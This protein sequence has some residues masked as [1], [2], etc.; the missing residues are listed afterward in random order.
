M[1]ASPHF[2]VQQELLDPPEEGH[3][4]REIHEIQA[5]AI[6]K[7]SLSAVRREVNRAYDIGSGADAKKNVRSF[8][9]DIPNEE[10][11]RDY[12]MLV[13]A[14]IAKTTPYTRRAISVEMNPMFSEHEKNQKISE[15]YASSPLHRKMLTLASEIHSNAL[16]VPDDFIR[17]KKQLAEDGRVWFD[18]E[19]DPEDPEDQ[20]VM[21]QFNEGLK[22]IKDDRGVTRPVI[23]S[24]NRIES[25][26]MFVD[27]PSGRALVEVI[28]KIGLD[29]SKRAKLE[30]ALEDDD[31]YGNGYA[32]LTRE[33][34]KSINRLDK[35]LS[36]I[37]GDSGKVLEIQPTGDPVVDLAIGL[38]K[39]LE[40]RSELVSD[41]PITGDAVSMRGGSCKDVEVYFSD[42]KNIQGE[43]Q[44]IEINGK[45]FW[46]KNHGAPTYINTEPVVF[47][48]INL[49]A[50]FVFGRSDAPNEDKGFYLMRATAFCFDD[51]DK[52]FEAFGPAMISG[53]DEVSARNLKKDIERF[54]EV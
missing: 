18:T 39:Q 16:N 52:A 11:E 42:S 33:I 1:E 54:P 53:A 29:L 46:H 2:A 21:G 17:V 30:L 15:V 31:R 44:E 47:N 12:K 43:F 7:R 35:E 34:A 49:P 6:T 37:K 19:F 10:F 23:E 20:V 48:G 5:Q 50:G 22:F 28:D 13:D 3:I 27:T 41:I 38:I 14:G 45:K 32:W 51:A 9:S 40:T 25:Q 36:V 8:K 24:V 4:L 26:G